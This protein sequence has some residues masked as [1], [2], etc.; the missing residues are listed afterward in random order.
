MC[1]ACAA[2]LLCSVCSLTR[3]RQMLAEGLH[4]ASDMQIWPSI[5]T[6]YT[7]LH[8]HNPTRTKKQAGARVFSPYDP[9]AMRRRL[10]FRASQEIDPMLLQR[11]V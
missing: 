2:V 9:E 5:A 1:C 10:P 8:V 3:S 11:V 7:D 4:L 6:Q